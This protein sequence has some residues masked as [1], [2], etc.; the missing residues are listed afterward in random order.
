[1]AQSQLAFDA[2]FEWNNHVLADELHYH[3]YHL[4]SEIQYVVDFGYI[5]HKNIFIFKKC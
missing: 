3:N 4:E 2:F 1:M 5:F